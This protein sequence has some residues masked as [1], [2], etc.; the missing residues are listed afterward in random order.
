MSTRIVHI[1][2]I[3]YE[4]LDESASDKLTD[5]L[6]RIEPD[7]LVVTGDL[8]DN[9]WCLGKAKDWLLR[10]C[11]EC[12]INHES[13]LIIVPGNHDYRILGN[14]GFKP[15]ATLFFRRYFGPWSRGK[16]VFFP[17]QGITFL[18]IDSN[19][20]L[21]G[22]ARGR[23]RGRQLRRL[24]KRIGGGSDQERRLIEKSTKIVLLH[25]HPLPVPYEGSDI[26]LML[27][28]AQ[29]LIQFLAENNVDMILHG[30][31][32][33]APYSLICLGT[34]VGSNRVIE[35][36]GAGTAVVGG[37]DMERRGR[38]FN[39]VTVEDSG[40]R[41]VRQ[42]FAQP[43]GDFHEISSSGFLSE[44]LDGVYQ[45]SLACGYGY[46]RVHW[47]VVI[48][49]EGDTFNEITYSGLSYRDEAKPLIIEPPSYCVD[50]GHLSHVWL[51]DSKTSP[52]VSLR[53]T[54]RERRE[55][56][57]E[58]RFGRRPTQADPV[59]FSVRSYDL[60]TQSLTLSEFRRNFPTRVGE[61]DYEEKEVTE[62]MGEL[63]WTL[64][65]PPNFRLRH[66]PAFEVYERSKDER[67]EWL[68]KVLQP[69]FFYSDVLKTASL[70]IHK[71]PVNYRYRISWRIPD[72]PA[73]TRLANP[74]HL[75]QIKHFEKRMLRM[76]N[77]YA[78][79]GE[80]P[81][82]TA[83]VLAVLQAFAHLV[84]KHIEEKTNVHGVLRPEDLDVSVVVYD[85]TDRN[86]PPILRVVA[87]SYM[88]DPQYW[89]FAL[90]VGDGN[91]GRAYKKNI[92]RSFDADRARQDPKSQTYV[93]VPNGSVHQFLYSMP[94]RH[95]VSG[96]LIFGILNLGGYSPA[97]GGLLRVLNDDE[98]NN[99][100]LDQS[101]VYV[102]T[103]LLEM[104][105]INVA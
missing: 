55:V 10:L 44:A 46:R 21:F 8:V 16:V 87:G 84:I 77:G 49:E 33:R 91:A 18:R 73:S 72:D 59:T 92:I 17:E 67:H 26:F 82:V 100:L 97:V 57:F 93:A 56:A 25:H 31:K 27:E 104:L 32:H 41:Y 4:R 23:I 34:C 13:N 2:D 5:C 22:F 45:R 71:P 1:S 51:N 102:L 64:K 39:L 99:W 58:V 36:L 35:V 63:S 70:S 83:E 19:P 12:G 9:P 95:P 38:N 61:S 50:T 65:F 60:N 40:L 86:R 30:H 15:L 98:G 29:D 81:G 79:G 85:D 103:R 3:H 80:V 69:C 28:N 96:D 7:F 11:C 42:F 37:A 48:D 47:D 62:P 90:E 89:D 24:K 78:P 88:A 53:V 68:T 20:I 43:G 75:V 74:G 101:Q 76:R 94:L 66:P 52:G 54:K 105:N 14:L 6:K